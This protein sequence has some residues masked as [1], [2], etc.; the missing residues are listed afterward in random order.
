MTA[1]MFL[2][3]EYVWVLGPIG[4]FFVVAF[5]GLLFVAARYK[6]CPSNRILVK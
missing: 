1:T 6:R 3:V 5:F 2:A 4:A